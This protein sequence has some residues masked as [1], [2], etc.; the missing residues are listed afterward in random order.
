M[1]RTL[2]PMKTLN[3]DAVAKAI[4]SLYDPE[5]GE[6]ISNLKLQK[7][8][9]YVQGFNLAVFNK[10]LFNEKIYAWQYGPVVKEVYNKYKT[11]GSASIT[12]PEDVDLDR[13]FSAKEKKLF[14]EVNKVYGQFSAGRLME[15]THSEPPWCSTTINGEI[16]HDKMRDFFVT[17]LAK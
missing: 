6:T 12:P 16:S 17:R 5:V 1:A 14:L 3:A 8:L 11:N 4:L 2:T 13:M 9:Y 15:M 7:L 10:P